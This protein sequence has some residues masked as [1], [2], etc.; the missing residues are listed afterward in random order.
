MAVKI[1]SIAFFLL[2]VLGILAWISWKSPS[3]ITAEMAFDRLFTAVN[4]HFGRMGE[5]MAQPEE[6]QKIFLD[7]VQ[8]MPRSPFPWDTFSHYVAAMGPLYA[9]EA[10]ALVDEARKRSPRRASYY[11]RQSQA[12]R[13]LGNL[14]KAV[15][16][17]KKAQQCSPKNPE[18]FD[19]EQN[20]NIR[21]EDTGSLW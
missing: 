16:M 8:R 21:Y 17:L 7:T 9:E 4:P 12:Y 14:P 18:Y 15:E 3:L 11:F 10:I 19:E 1:F 2:S 5:K 13:R 20:W 6:A